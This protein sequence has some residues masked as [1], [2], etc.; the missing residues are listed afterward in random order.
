MT[1]LQRL[2]AYWYKLAFCI[3]RTT[4]FSKQLYRCWPKKILLALTGALYDR[5]HFFIRYNWHALPKYFVIMNTLKIIC[6]SNFCIVRNFQKLQ[7]HFFLDFL[8]IF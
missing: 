3:G 1:I 7:K 4:A 2:R 5:F 6:T 8:W